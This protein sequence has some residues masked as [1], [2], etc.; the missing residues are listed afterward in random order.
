MG[1]QISLRHFRCFVAVARTGSFTL[2]AQQLFKTQSSLTATIKQFE[3]LAGVQ[4][5]DRTTRR[6]EQ[7]KDALWFLEVAEGV[8]RDFDNAVADLQAVGRSE[9][10][11]IKISVVPSMMPHILAPTLKAFRKSYPDVKI[12]VRDEGSDKTERAVLDGTTDFGISSP[13][14]HFPDLDYRPVLADRFGVVFPA[15]H[16]LSKKK[17]DLTWADLREYDYVALTGDTGIGALTRHFPNFELRHRGT[18]VDYASSTTSLHALLK[19]GDRI[20]VLPSLAAHTGE[21][22]EFEFRELHD[23]KIEREVC[24]IT[25]HLR[26]SSPTTRRALEILLETIREAPPVQGVRMIDTAES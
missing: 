13:L 12:S 7:T 20:T 21:M 16:P 26:S 2:A 3:E 25:R 10:G 4:L 22:T 11:N 18:D 1:A 24:V 15:D 17:G 6:V 19:L 14:N 8:L 9:H 23:P 5:F